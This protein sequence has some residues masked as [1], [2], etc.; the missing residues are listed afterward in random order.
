MKSLIIYML[1]SMSILTTNAQTFN[2]WFRQKE[3]QEK[4]LVQQLIGL[5]VYANYL[6]KGYQA[7]DKGSKT[8]N[9]I[10]NGDFTLHDLFFESQK[11]LNSNMLKQVDGLNI[12]SLKSLIHQR[13]HILDHF[14]AK[15]QLI[16]VQQKTSI[17]KILKKVRDDEIQLSNRYDELTKDNQLALDDD[18]RLERIK[19]LKMDY[20]SLYG[21]IRYF[22]IQVKSYS[23]QIKN[24][25]ND[26]SSSKK[27]LGIK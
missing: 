15:D 3:T 20:A 24:E 4:Y 9:K 17:K 23:D 8:I 11:S 5:E 16:D 10:K 21:F 22:E 26:L 14:T 12:G 7:I 2:E 13:I 1:C 25:Q 19:D 18:H 27:L 6:K